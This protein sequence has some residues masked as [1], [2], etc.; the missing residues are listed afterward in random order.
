MGGR[1]LSN[2][3]G[4]HLA[5]RTDVKGKDREQNGGFRNDAAGGPSH[6]VHRTASLSSLAA[7]IDEQVHTH[8]SASSTGNDTL[9]S[10]GMSGMSTARTSAMLSY[11]DRCEPPVSTSTSIYAH[12]AT[13]VLELVSNTASSS[14]LPDNFS[15][16]LSRKG[17]FTCVFTTSTIWLIKA[18]QLPRLW[19]RTLQVKRKPVAVDILEDGSLLAVLSRPSQVDV[20]EIYGEHDRQVK[21]RRTIMLVHEAH[22]M[23]ISPDGLI[24][25]TG[26]TF[27]IEV[28]SIGPDAPET[29]RRTLSGPVGDTLEFSEDGRT[30]LITSYARKSGGTS[31]FV[32]PGLYDGPLNEEGEPMPASPEAVWTGLVLFPETTRIARQATLLPDA[33]TGTVNELFAFNADED[34]WG[35]YDIGAQRFTQRKMFLP[36]QQRWTRSEF[37]DD[38]MPAVS[39][40][41]DL[42]A[43]A[44]K[45][46]GTT[47]LWIYQVPDWDYQPNSQ[48]PDQT[49]IQ[50][51]FCVPILRDSQDANQE[52]CELRW[53]RIDDNIQRLVAVGN[54]SKVIVDGEDSVDTPC[55]KGVII[56]LDFD[57]TRPASSSSPAPI[58]MEY[59]LDPLLPGER[60]P[61]G[62]IDFER[63]VELVRTRT[64]AQR[65]AQSRAGDGRRNSRQGPPPGRARTTANRERAPPMPTIT[66]DDEG[67]LTMEEAQAAF[68]APYDN[69]QPRSQNSLAR[70]ATV[71]AVSPANRRHL[72]SLPFRP[73]DYRRADGMR[74]FP[75]ESDADN[76]VPPPPAYTA[77]AEE[78]HSVSLSH[79][80]APPDGMRSALPQNPP[81]PP[82]PALPTSVN[83]SQAAAHL[84]QHRPSLASQSSSDLTLPGTN[85]RPALLHPST[86][87]SPQSPGP[88]RRRS[89][90]TQHSPPPQVQSQPP[91]NQLQSA[92]NA[93]SSRHAVSS[94]LRRSTLRPNRAIE[95]QVDLRPPPL[96]TA[97]MANGPR[98]GSAPDTAAITRRPVGA[99]PS[100]RANPNRMSMPPNGYPTAN[101]NTN[102]DPRSNGKSKSRRSILPRLLPPGNHHSTRADPASAPPRSHRGYTPHSAA[103]VAPVQRPAS[104]AEHRQYHFGMSRQHQQHYSQHEQGQ[105]PQQPNS[106]KEKKKTACVVM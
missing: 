33:D 18:T 13:T 35:I 32:L 39:V 50:P 34:T 95:S 46:R 27:G 91:S 76:W 65:R 71:A 23:R 80:G 10:S 3:D 74:E 48:M 106:A 44:L 29:S 28:I 56:I 61:E 22:S 69:T 70:A 79:P 47:S 53:V 25:I 4:Q 63:E 2:L 100:A 88:G 36:D 82:V 1:R 41:A 12:P 45:M 9:S 66:R 24:L 51:C 83:A 52:I 37:L 7:S 26:N 103:P 16:N 62:D 86:Y 11:D 57:K 101:A 105:H 96:I 6:R 81:F 77:S 68:E 59:D 93:T 43:V 8:L 75:H 92:Y 64:M 72:R 55:S 89:S 21:K 67:E 40:N 99:P 15:F 94:I 87:P 5:I 54:V 49:P 104:S 38:A 98:R 97:S 20:Y 60:L 102:P 14:A 31:L 84:S 30:L 58:K 17:E 19:A 42:A 90:A 73:L 85:A 78:S